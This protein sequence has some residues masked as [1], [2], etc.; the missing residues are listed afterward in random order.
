MGAVS[1]TS[2][3]QVTIPVSVRRT[4]GIEPGTKVTFTAKNG[5]AQLHVEKQRRH[6]TLVDGAGMIA[7]KGNI[8][9]KAKSKSRS[10]LS[11]DVA[12]TLAP[13]KRTK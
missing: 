4:L 6:T 11:F 2:K 9:N 12:T 1:V 13:L 5:V 7:L 10:L 3:G 8:S